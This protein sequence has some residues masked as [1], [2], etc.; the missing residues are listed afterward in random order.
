MKLLNS[1]GK[2]HVWMNDYD[3]RKIDVGKQ[4]R[5]FLRWRVNLLILG[6]A[7]AMRIMT[8]A[9]ALATWSPARRSDR[10]R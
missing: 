8:S 5:V 1:Y 9:A 3:Y 10:Q 6:S 7:V 2:H 4:L